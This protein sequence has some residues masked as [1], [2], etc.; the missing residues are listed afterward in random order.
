MTCCWR[1][2]PV[3]DNSSWMSSSRHVT[4]LSWYSDSPSRKSVRVIVT[5]VNSIGSSRAVLSMVSDTSDRPSADRS[6]VPAK[7]TSS[8][9]PPRT[10]RGPWAPSTQATASTRF[11]LPEPFGPTTTVTPGSNSSTVLSANDL[12]PR[13]VRDLRN[14]REALLRRTR[15][16]LAPSQAPALRLR[17]AKPPSPPARRIV[18]T[19]IALVG[20]ASV[21]NRA[22]RT[23]NPCSPT[24]ASSTTSTRSTRARRGPR[25]HHARTSSTAP[26]G[27]SS[28]TSTRPSARLRTQPATPAACAWSRHDSRNHTPCTLPDT[29]TRRRMVRSLIGGTATGA[30]GGLRR[31][32]TARPPEVGGWGPP[33]AA[34]RPARPPASHLARLAE[35]RGPPTDA[36]ADDRLAA[37]PA[38]LALAGV[39]L[40]VQLVLAR[41]PVEVDVLLVGERGA[42]MLHRFLQRL[43]HRAIEPSDLLARQRV[44]HAVPSQSGA[45]E[46]LVAVDVADAGKELLVHQQ[47][48][49]L[50]VLRRDQATEVVPRH[51]VLERVD[52]EVGELR[53]LLLD[54]VELGD[55][56]L[57][58]GARVDEAQ[59]TALGERDHDM[60]VLGG[61]LARSLGPNELSG[62]PEV[63]HEDV[64]PVEPRQD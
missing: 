60:R 35:E 42:A 63:D 57:A 31:P 27:P 49:E 34:R 36:L 19:G 54:A 28:T 14:T 1:P 26:G 7:M 21:K 17:S 2:M 15:F 55:E 6:G 37:A 38:R 25:R 50:H 64:T 29:Q 61:R 43:D 24:G 4:P 62:H 47:A 56:H 8:M 59:L 13:R 11:D 48:L 22:Y 10:V 3:S 20:D 9:R 40:V 46:D 44:A 23:R 51:G 12:K 18:P 58:E 52:A 32:S 5:S 45:E 53:H 33:T 30:V 16:L 41:L 39:H